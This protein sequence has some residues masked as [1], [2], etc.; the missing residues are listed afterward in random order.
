MTQS[1]KDTR[2]MRSVAAD[3]LAQVGGD[4]DDAIRVLVGAL[5]IVANG[6]RS[7]TGTIADII[8]NLHAHLKLS[9]EMARHE[10]PDSQLS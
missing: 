10:L 2:D 6:S 4:G 9:A 5:I 1:E 8:V 3:A 7:P